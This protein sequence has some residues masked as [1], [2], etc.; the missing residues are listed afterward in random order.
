MGGYLCCGAPSINHVH[1]MHSSRALSVHELT[2]SASIAQQAPCL[3]F[4][5][6]SHWPGARSCPL[7]TSGKDSRD[8]E[9]CGGCALK[10]AVCICTRSATFSRPARRPRQGGR[11]M[12]RVVGLP[13]FARAGSTARLSQSHAAF[14]GLLSLLGS[15][16]AV[17]LLVRSCTCEDF[18]DA[19]LVASS[20]AVLVRPCSLVLIVFPA[21]RIRHALLAA[22]KRSSPDFWTA[23]S[24]SRKRSRTTAAILRCA[25]TNRRILGNSFAQEVYHRAAAAAVDGTCLQDTRAEQQHNTSPDT[26][27]AF[28]G[29]F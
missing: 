21:A 19:V 27:A 29:Q 16:K 20:T 17:S 15:G 18:N 24:P 25:Y 23:R 6:L 9:T 11:G 7:R 1:G 14:R 10:S 8:R 26:G 3:K 13:I 4:Q 2:S 5:G 28:I 22:A 12:R